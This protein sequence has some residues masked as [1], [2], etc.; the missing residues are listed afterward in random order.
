MIAIVV[1]SICLA[2]DVPRLN[3]ESALHYTL[4]Y[5]DYFWTLLFFCEMMSKVVSFGFACG[6]GTY[7]TNPWNLLDLVIVTVS[8]LVLLAEFFPMFEP[9]K[10][11]RILR[12]LR[13]LR[14]LARN[15]GM[16]LIIVSLFKSMPAVS[17][18][19]GVVIAF[20]LVRPRRHPSP[21]LPFF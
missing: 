17:N 12:V 5:L 15:E 10:M 3:E 18:V 16:K 6:E 13:P 8:F 19:F 14:L 2:L 4:H 7:V 11:L 9:L 21:S 20:Q 1:S